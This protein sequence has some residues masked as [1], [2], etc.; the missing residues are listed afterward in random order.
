[1]QP[2]KVNTKQ[3]FFIGI[4]QPPHCAKMQQANNTFKRLFLGLNFSGNATYL[5]ILFKEDKTRLFCLKKGTFKI[6][7]YYSNI[8]SN[9][10]YFTVLK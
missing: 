9:R 5:P 8:F 2:T 4:W 3:K 1:M 6:L 7:F 10:I